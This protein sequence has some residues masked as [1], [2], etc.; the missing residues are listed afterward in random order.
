MDYI[1]AMATTDPKMASLPLSQRAA[2]MRTSTATQM[3]GKAALNQWQGRV[4]QLLKANQTA[5]GSGMLDSKGVKDQEYV[6]NLE[7]FV[8]KVL[9][10]K[11]I[12]SLD[13]TSGTK[14][15]QMINAVMAVKNDPKKMQTAFQDL[16]AITTA[17]RMDP[18][19][20]GTAQ[21]SAQQPGGQ[22]AVQNTVQGTKIAL[23]GINTQTLAQNMVTANNGQPVVA[24][25]TNNDLVNRVLTAM[26]VQ[27][28]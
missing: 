13:N 27:L 1:K 15:N 16:V 6:D 18:A 17:A 9:L 12:E 21:Q 5:G 4:L 28:T 26:G 7:D 11:P 14:L 24:T 25:K 22:Q 19:K 2:A 10:Q 3:L 20:S 23:Q 8:E